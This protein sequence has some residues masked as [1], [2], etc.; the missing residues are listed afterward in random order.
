MVI[1][2]G[3][4][5]VDTV[6]NC[7]SDESRRIF[8]T[9]AKIIFFQTMASA[10]SWSTVSVKL[11]ERA[12]WRLSGAG[13]VCFRQYAA[14]L[15]DV[16][17][18]GRILRLGWVWS[19]VG[20]LGASGQPALPGTEALAPASDRSE[21]MVAGIGRFLDAEIAAS[22]RGRER[23]WRPDFQSRVDYEKS[24]APNRARL[25]KIL[26]VVDERVSLP[27]MEYAGDVTLG[28]K[29]AETAGMIAYAVRWPV[30]AGVM[31]EGVW[32]RPKGP[33]RARVVAVP[34]AD[35]TPEMIAGLVPGV[36]GAYH[37]AR[38]L[39]ESGCEVIVPTL[40]N[41]ADDYA[42]NVRLGRLTNQP[43]REWIYRQAYVVGRHVIGYEVQ[44][45]LAVVD[46]FSREGAGAR[47]PIG[48]TGWG[49]GGLL[50]LA[51]AALDGRI[52]AALVSGYFGPREK[53]GEEP[54]YRN[55]FGL[56]REFGDAEM[57]RL[58]VPRALIVEIA[59][60]PE[61]AG[62]PLARVRRAGAA[63]GRLVT[64]AAAAV[65]AEVA[66]AQRLA[67]PFSAA[68][69]G[70]EA[71]P[72]AGETLAR[73][74]AA[75]SP[76]SG[77][78]ASLGGAAEVAWGAEAMALAAVER[79]RRQVGE[80]QAFTQRQLGLAQGVREAFFWQKVPV[81]TPADWREATRGFRDK[82]WED[83]IGKFPVGQR[84]PRARTRWLSEEAQW[85]AY[86]VV[87]DVLPEVEAWGYLLLP[88]GMRPGE[89][90]PVVVAQHGLEGLPMDV[91]DPDPT[92]RA[93]GYYKAFAARLAERG[94][95]VFAP[96][97]PY[98]GEDAF[99]WLQ[100]KANPL[101]KSLYSIILAQHEVILDW[102]A[103]QP[104]VDAT[105]MG[106]YGLSYGGKTAMRVP[107][108]LDRYAL[109][110]CSADFNEWIYKLMTTEWGGSYMFTKEWEIPDF[111][112]GNT[113]GYAEMAALIAPRPF[114]VE[115][116]HDD[117]V[118]TDEWVAFEYAKVNRLYS[119]LKI[120]ERTA[121]EYFVGPHTINGVG[122]FKFLHRH[123]N[124]PEPTP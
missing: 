46:W 89:R 4:E 116:G 44:K 18:S 50:A 59:P 83:V 76:G 31:G 36:P 40:I 107:A 21:R 105:R 109:S 111:D 26:G 98:R 66:R 7:V 81:T 60:G 42:G 86:E 37:Y 10:G 48:I 41:R 84:A 16:F 33:T 92:H 82:F 57:A 106:F 56:L 77:P 1:I 65:R 29:L 34:D 100:R 101:G 108:L 68:I 35:Q 123:L 75:L 11:L 27:S 124:W 63:P 119:R 104:H 61:V 49:E 79:Q 9:M 78:A 95:I 93:Y 24:L 88:K 99:R 115:R 54:I 120:P 43:H 64:P 72:M 52:E 55:V 12:A 14:R 22:E 113:F 8:P 80:L 62:P 51:A 30:L 32:L 58:I 53:I 20:L 102:L 28:A 19:L 47:V 96:H 103:T 15:F 69:Q 71:G 67:G 121:I 94:F 6:V 23:F 87:L 97:N 45:I 5:S 73:F 118:G 90:R 3:M 25:A 114:M 74:W 112:L 17:E 117:G 85:T 122:T 110:I 70:L 2:E 91:I 13:W 39:A 38:W